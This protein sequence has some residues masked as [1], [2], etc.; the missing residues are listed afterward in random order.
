L[1]VGETGAAIDLAAGDRRPAVG[2][3]PLV[4]RHELLRGAGAAAEALA[5]LPRAPPEVRA[6]LL[7]GTKDVELLDASLTDVRDPHVTGHAVEG[8]TPRVADA[9]HVDLGRATTTRERVVGGDSV[10]ES[11]LFVVD[12]DAQHLGEQRLGV[13]HRAAVLERLAV[14]LR[15]AAAAAVAG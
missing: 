15:I 6:L 2:V 5:R 4:L 8:P 7:C 1:E 13:R 12:V 9:D 3:Q 11:A 10:F 14:L